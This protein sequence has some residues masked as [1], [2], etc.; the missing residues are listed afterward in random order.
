MMT[1][2]I[3]SESEEFLNEIADY[4][5]TEELI[6]NAMISSDVLFKKKLPDGRIASSNHYVLKGISKSLLFSDI[7]RGLKE[8]YKD[9]MPLVYSEPII[10]ID[11]E[12]TEMIL[13][14]I[15]K[16]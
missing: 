2:R 14:R 3:V 5:L 11:C 1:L 6:A 9:N 15:T 7:N 12:H 13:D 16:V 8:K 4:L 10:L